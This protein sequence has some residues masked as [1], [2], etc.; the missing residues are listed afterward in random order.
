MYR[1]QFEILIEKSFSDTLFNTL[2]SE[3]IAIAIPWPTKV[4]TPSHPPVSSF[5][6]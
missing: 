4:E 2:I 5:A 3:L 6:S 1:D